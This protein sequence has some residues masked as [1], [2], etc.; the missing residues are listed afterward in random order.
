MN[1]E[2]GRNGVSVRGFGGHWA[3]GGA[4]KEPLGGTAN[5]APGATAASDAQSVVAFVGERDGF[6]ALVGEVALGGGELRLAG[7]AVEGEIVKRLQVFGGNDGIGLRRRGI[8]RSGSGLQNDGGWQG[9]LAWEFA[10]DLRR[11]HDGAFVGGQ[12]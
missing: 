2:L 1:C 11:S 3:S 10:H 9:D 12:G 8:L 4:D 5:A 7:L 6:L